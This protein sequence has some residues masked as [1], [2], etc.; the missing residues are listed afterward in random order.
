M[1][2]YQLTG[3]EDAIQLY[4]VNFY[5]VIDAFKYSSEKFFL[6]NWKEIKKGK[7]WQIIAG[8]R[9]YKIELKRVKREER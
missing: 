5:S 4:E 9:I 6:R 2:T 7:L 8:N 3:M 1:Q